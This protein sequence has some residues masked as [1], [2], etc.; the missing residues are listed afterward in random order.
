MAEAVK[1]RLA[2]IHFPGLGDGG[3]APKAAENR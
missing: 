1:G 2:V 3:P